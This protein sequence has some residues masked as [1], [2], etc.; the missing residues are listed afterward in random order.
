LEIQIKKKNVSAVLKIFLK[1]GFNI[2][3][4][5]KKTKN[6]QTKKTKRKQNKTKQKKQQK[7]NKIGRL[8]KTNQPLKMQ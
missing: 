8:E 7:K 2:L 4:K 6:K 1:L 3:L 5:N